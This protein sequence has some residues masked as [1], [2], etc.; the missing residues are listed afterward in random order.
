MITHEAQ[1]LLFPDLL[2]DRRTAIEADVAAAGGLQIVGL[3]L[4]LDDDPI[5]AGKKLSNKIQRN[6]RHDLKDEEVWRIK[7][8]A[9]KSTGKSRLHEL[10][11]DALAFEGRWLTSEDIKARRKKRKAALLAELLELEQEDE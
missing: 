11:S 2:A 5:E 7:E 10:E 3:A 6:G 8:L 4:K 9:R 1:R